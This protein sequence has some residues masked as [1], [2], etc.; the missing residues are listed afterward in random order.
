[1]KT[2]RDLKKVE[3]THDRSRCRDEDRFMKFSNLVTLR[4]IGGDPTMS[5]TV[6]SGLD[7]NVSVTLF[8]H[9]VVPVEHTLYVYGTPAFAYTESV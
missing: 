1:V 8:E 6:G 7:Q 4:C 9:V 3:K 2:P 5:R